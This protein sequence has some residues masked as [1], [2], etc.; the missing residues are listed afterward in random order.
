MT[1][2]EIQA[3]K[4]TN[5]SLVARVTQLE[6]INL[7][8]VDQKKELKIKLTEGFNDADMKA[9]LDNYKAQLG[10]VESEKA[11][12]QSGFT[13]KLSKLQMNNILR[14]LG[15]KAQT[16]EAL[17]K[18]AE[19]VLADATA[20]EEG[21]FKFLNEDK[22]TRFNEAKNEYGVMDKINELKEGGNSFY[23]APEKGAGGGGD[24]P[25][26]GATKK[27]DINSIIDAGLKY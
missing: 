6:S 20:T 4:D 25:D 26:P 16:P 27:T 12:L 7:D 19:M 21:A 11:E 22:T 15:I 10:N 23:F 5:E 18:I 13:E 14:D 2:E 9:E 3:L 24:A 8:L 17:E 1:P